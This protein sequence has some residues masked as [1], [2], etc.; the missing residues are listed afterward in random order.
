MSHAN[1]LLSIESA[2]SAI[3]LTHYLVALGYTTERSCP[4]EITLVPNNAIMVIKCESE[5]FERELILEDALAK[6]ITFH[7][8]ALNL[9]CGFS[10]VAI[11][12]SVWHIFQHA[13]HYLRPYE[14]KY[15]IRI[16]AIIPINAFT[17][18]LGYVFYRNSVYWELVRGCYEAYAIAS[19]FTLLCHYVAPTLHEQKAYLRNVRPKNWAWPLNWLQKLT[20]GED[21]GCLRKPRSGLTW[22]NIIYVGVYQYCIVRLLFTIV[23]VI[24]Q[25]QGKYCQSSK[26]PQ[27][28]SLWVSGFEGISVT[29]AMYCLVQFYIQLKEDLGEHRP[30]LKILSIKLVIFLCFWQN[31]L[32]ALLTTEN[33]PLKPNKLVAGPDLRIG[34][35]CI[36]TCVEMA[37]FALLH[38]R[39]FPWKPYDITSLARH[40]KQYYACGPNEA[41]LEAIYPWDYAKAAARGVRWLVHGVR[42][43]KDDPSYQSEPL[44]E[45]DKNS[46]KKPLFK[47]RTETRSDSG[48]T[49]SKNRK[50]KKRKT[51]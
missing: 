41:I 18:F 43:R 34:I 7:L 33:G 46:T 28:A 6:E 14:Q 26:H 11:A 27:F 5:R 23:A 51:A 9:C 2:T 37:F 44:P 30:F 12:I 35:P 29:I 31:F 20:G 13:L 22:F 21:K 49:G 15:I 38:R 42:F 50:D 10:C 25:S 45:R 3:A 32:I 39:A 47:I 24:S 19:F 8:L 1:C 17:S 16:L 36:L 40:P 48:R 4:S